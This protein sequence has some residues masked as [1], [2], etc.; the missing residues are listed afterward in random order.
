MPSLTRP[1]FDFLTD[2]TTP[3]LL[4]C[5]GLG[6]GKSLAAALKALDL[7]MSNPGEIGIVWGPTIRDAKEN[8]IYPILQ[9]LNGDH[10]SGFHVPIPYDHNKGTGYITVFPNGRSNPAS[11]IIVRSGEQD[12]VGVNA[13]WAIADELDTLKA[14]KARTA[15]QQLTQRV[16][17]PGASIKQLCATTTPEGFRFCWQAWKQEVEAE[18]ELAKYRR[19]IRASLLSNPHI[20]DAYIQQ[21]MQ[22]HTPSEIQARVHGHFVNFGSSRVYE[23]FDRDIHHTERTLADYPNATITVGL[24]FNA[25]KMAAVVG[26][27]LPNSLLIF[28][29]HI[30]TKERPILDTPSMIQILKKSYPNRQIHICPDASGENRN[31]NNGLVTSVGELQRAGFICHHDKANPRVEL[32]ISNVN[33]ML[34]ATSQERSPSLLINTRTCPLLTAALEQQPYNE[35]GTPDKTGDWDHPLDSLGYLVVQRFGDRLAQAST[36]PWRH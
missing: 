28:A 26:V 1:Q 27:V 7:S 35:L 12:V 21:L 16:R 10:Q 3:N 29:E 33:R 18:P 9:V 34:Y 36:S 14:A 20:E 24:D 32:R 23:Y 30:G 2:R 5:A 11:Q 13:G 4:F 8:V 17:S 31:A 25:G 19:L 6:A 22:S 15:W